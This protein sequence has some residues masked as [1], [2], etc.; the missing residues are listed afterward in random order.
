MTLRNFFTRSFDARGRFVRLIVAM[1]K[2]EVMHGFGVDENTGLY[3]ENQTA[4]VYGKWGV[5]IVDTSAATTIPN[6]R[7]Y[8]SAENVRIHYLTEGDSYDLSS[9]DVFTAKPSIDEQETTVETSNNIFGLDQGLRTIKALISSNSTVSEGY[10]REEDPTCVVVF[11]KDESTKGFLDDDL[12]TI[13]DLLL[14]VKTKGISS[15][16]IYDK[17]HL[18][19]VLILAVV[20][21][22]FV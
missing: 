10:S 13:R 3:I 14:H 19:I 6:D 22:K 12:Y 4:T 2:I 11:E 8:F 21:A 5:W 18:R 20:F 7:Q 15:A 16:T 17:V 1:R 9:G